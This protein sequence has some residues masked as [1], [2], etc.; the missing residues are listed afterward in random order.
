MA[1]P[2]TPQDDSEAMPALDTTA[3]V[4]VADAESVAE[5]PDP[6]PAPA[7]VPER[8]PDPVPVR[9]RRRGG[10][11]P[12]LL[13]GVIAA[14]I[15]FAAAEYVTHPGWPLSPPGPTPEAIAQQVDALTSDLATVKREV[16]TLAPTVAALQ[17]KADTSDALSAR[18]D[19]TAK[20]AAGQIAALR[21]DLTTRNDAMK[22]AIAA[23]DARAAAIEKQGLAAGVAGGNADM[24]VLD[25]LRVQLEDQRKQNETLAAQIADVADKAN[26]RID[27]AEKQAAAL[28]ADADAKAKVA[29]ARAALTRVE[30]ALELG[31]GFTSA[32][33]DLAAQG[34]KVPDTLT[35]VA[36][37]GVP[38][39]VDLREAFPAAARAALAA[40]IKATM[41]PSLT[42]RIGAFFRAQTGLRSLTARPGSDPDAVLSRAEADANAGKLEEALR[43][44][45][46][47]PEAGRAAMEGWMTDAKTRMSALAAVDAVAQ[48][49]GSK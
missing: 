40:S 20:D 26:A 8:K 31:G 49:L 10:F 23:L 28:K 24:A 3:E 47:L 15:G 39:L 45:A 22:Q 18:I 33:A 43:E 44:L 21:D 11:G 37:T 5:T 30:A 6:E 7:S 46:A 1:D 13:G 14:G 9:P 48:G 19:T 32:L 34:A 35:A 36:S 4:Q 29:L 12:A 27:A 38:T 25:S 2:D 41:G 17:A 42:D 16:T